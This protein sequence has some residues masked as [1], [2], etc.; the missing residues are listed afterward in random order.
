[1]A[2]GIRRATLSPRL[3][4]SA[5]YIVL[6]ILI[7]AVPLLASGTALA[8]PVAVDQPPATYLA[9]AYLLMA[10][11]LP[12]N[13][14]IFSLALLVVS[15]IRG[16]KVGALQ[17]SRRWFLWSVILTMLIVSTVGAFLDLTLVYASSDVVTVQQIDSGLLRWTVATALIF[18]S[19]FV[20]SH[21]LISLRPES[22]LATAAVLAMANPVMWYLLT[23]GDLGIDGAVALVIFG[24][25]LSGMVLGLLA[26]WHR[27]I[28]AKTMLS[29]PRLPAK[30]LLNVSVAYFAVII[31]AFAAAASVWGLESDEPS[32]SPSTTLTKYYNGWTGCWEFTIGYVQPG[33]VSWNDIS[34]MLIEGESHV[35]WRDLSSSDLA[36]SAGITH[37]YGLRSLGLLE[38]NLTV[39]DLAG[40]GLIGMGDRLYLGCAG[41]PED[42]TFSIHLVYEPT[43]GTVAQLGFTR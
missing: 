14:L 5:F 13:L 42:V 37:D 36:G 6:V 25:L 38:V 33:E 3:R 43:D 20:P 28:Y 7:P 35:E 39:R 8:N 41:W 15:V 16:A 4:F 19:V 34:I 26:I 11:N 2:R 18:V 31:I 17:E 27:E 29:P 22:N 1:M 12:I 30:H 40:D 21:F 24:V 10:L 23:P 32:S 9:I